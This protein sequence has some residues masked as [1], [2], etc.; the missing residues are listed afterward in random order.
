MRVDGRLDVGKVGKKDFD[1][2]LKELVESAHS[3]AAHDD[4]VDAFTGKRVERHTHAWSVVMR[5]GVGE[6]P[7]RPRVRVDDQEEWGGPE[8]GAN[9]AL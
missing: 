7:A 6:C 1:P 4:G 3:D 8:M 5:V 2:C 9:R